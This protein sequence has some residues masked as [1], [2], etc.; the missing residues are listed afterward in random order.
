VRG[1]CNERRDSKAFFEWSSK[2][3]EGRFRRWSTAAD[4]SRH[5]KYAKATGVW[6]M[7]WWDEFWRLRNR[8]MNDY[9]LEVNHKTPIKGGHST[10]GH[11]HHLEGLEVLC[12]RCHLTETRD[13]REKG[14][15]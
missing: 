10:Y 7:V 11:L 13:Q 14:L 15:L 8:L 9:G 2:N 6:S 4:R 12:G 5:R 3:P 1:C